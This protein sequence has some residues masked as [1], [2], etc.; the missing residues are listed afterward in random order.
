MRA[1]ALASPGSP[2][3][4]TCEPVVS[5]KSPARGAAPSG[6]DASDRGTTSIELERGVD[7][8]RAVYEGTENWATERFVRLEIT[9]FE[10]H[11]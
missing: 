4:T 11:T 5:P 6:A 2:S 3:S 7:S 9:G 1:D 8:A 10:P